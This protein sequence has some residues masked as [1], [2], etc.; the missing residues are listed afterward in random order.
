MA[1]YGGL[2]MWVWD[3]AQNDPD[4]FCARLAKNNYGYVVVKAHDGSNEYNSPARVDQW[5]MA[6]RHHGLRFGI[7]GYTYHGSDA[8]TAVAVIERHGADFYVADAEIEYEQGY[9]ASAEFASIFRKLKPH[10]PAAMSSFGRVDFHSLDWAAWAHHGF[11]FMPQAYECESTA[12]APYLCVNAAARYWKRQQIF[13]VLGSYRGARGLLTGQQLH[14][15][16]V[17]IAL[18]G[19]S[20]WDSQELHGDQVEQVGKLAHRP[21]PAPGHPAKPPAKPPWNKERPHRDLTLTSPLTAGLDVKHLQQAINDRLSW[22]GEKHLNID[23]VFG[24]TT[25]HMTRVAAYDIGLVDYEATQMVQRLVENPWQ[26]NPRQR[27]REQ[28]RA[29]ALKTHRSQSGGGVV[30]L[31]RIAAKYIGVAESPPGSNRGTPYPSD[32]ERHFGM[33]GVSWCG[34]FAGSMILAAGGHVDSRVA[35]C[36]Y[37]EADAK[38]HANG[39][40]AW[41]TDH[42]QA[43]P[44]WLVL[45][46]WDGSGLPEHVGIVES[47]AAGHLVAI[48]GNTSGT[49]PSDG[50]MVA[51]MTRG[52]GPVV[53]YARPR[54]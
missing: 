48:E 27:A 9:G 34:C 13:P 40:D 33:D 8:R 6:C 36:P 52:Y 24:Q 18:P 15:S 30:S 46:C 14:D 43:G 35:Y 41:T 39:F 12:D 44:G 37:I 50:G 29:K 20:V 3:A 28:Q 25:H 2:G 42:R 47:F 45:Y 49:N 23:G 21:P 5:R 26:R 16:V 11:D 17:H 31:P 19:V 51:R 54:L 4:L 38:V 7:W 1:P 53:G 22:R 32:W 10:F